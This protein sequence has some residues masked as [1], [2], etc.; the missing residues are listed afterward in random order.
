MATYS[1][2]TID[3]FAA[4]ALVVAATS[5]VTRVLPPMQKPA[6]YNL[7][8]VMDPLEAQNHSAQ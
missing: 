3:A 4:C 5:H 2:K 6:S 7:T 1:K 8:Q